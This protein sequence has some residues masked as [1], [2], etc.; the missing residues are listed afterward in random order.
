MTLNVQGFTNSS[1]IFPGP[2]RWCHKFCSAGYRHAVGCWKQDWSFF[3]FQVS[4][5]RKHLISAPYHSSRIT[6]EL[7]VSKQ[8]WILY[9]LHVCQCFNIFL[10]S[11]LFFHV[12][13]MW[14]VCA[15]PRKT[16]GPTTETLHGTMEYT[17]LLPHCQ[18]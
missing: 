18:H 4:T 11:I 7:T 12:E 15:G 16:S 8:S 10:P 6:V 9:I 13:V 17:V 1:P 3:S 5:T 2:L 14:H